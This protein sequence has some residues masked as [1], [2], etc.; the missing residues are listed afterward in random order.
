MSSIINIVL[1]TLAAS[2]H[3]QDQPLD[4]LL[5]RAQVADDLSAKM[6]DSVMAK[7]TNEDRKT[8]QEKKLKKGIKYEGYYPGEDNK[9]GQKWAVKDGDLFDDG[10]EYGFFKGFFKAAFPKTVDKELLRGEASEFGNKKK[11]YGE[12]LPGAPLAGSTPSQPRGFNPIKAPIRGAGS[13]LVRGPFLFADT[14]SIPSPLLVMIGLFAGSG[15]AFAFHR[16][17]SHLAMSQ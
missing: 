12:A 4:K 7:A 17:R 13:S 10:T 2:A 9:S 16:L 5:N 8:R 14:T 6:D 3:A 11:F 1:F 15:V